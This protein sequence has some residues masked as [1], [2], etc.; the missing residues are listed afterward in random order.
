MDSSNISAALY[1]HCCCRWW[2]RAAGKGSG[3]TQAARVRCIC[4]IWTMVARQDL[5]TRPLPDKLGGEYAACAG[6]SP[7]QQRQQRRPA[8]STGDERAKGGGGV[9]TCGT[10]PCLSFQRRLSRVHV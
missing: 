8:Y 6:Y 9:A 7:R 1:A 10:C 2:M 5:L 3:P 4:S